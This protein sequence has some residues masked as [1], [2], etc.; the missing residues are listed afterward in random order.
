MTC[1][2]VWLRFFLPTIYGALPDLQSVVIRGVLEAGSCE[3]RGTGMVTRVDRA[4]E[5][6]TQASGSVSCEPHQNASTYA[7]TAILRGYVVAHVTVVPHNFKVYEAHRIM[8]DQ[9]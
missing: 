8:A 1:H 7:R 9:G 3:R 4:N 2:T 5:C 6:L